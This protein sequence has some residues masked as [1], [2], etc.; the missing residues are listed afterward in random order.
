M[1]CACVEVDLVRRMV[2]EDGDVCTQVPQD[3]G[4]GTG[5]IQADSGDD[6]NMLARGGNA[7]HTTVDAVGEADVIMNNA[8]GDKNPVTDDESA[9]MIKN[10]TAN[11]GIRVQVDDEAELTK[12]IGTTVGL[13]TMEGFVMT[14]HDRVDHATI[15][16]EETVAEEEF[17]GVQVSVESKPEVEEDEEGGGDI[18]T[19]DN[20]EAGKFEILMSKQECFGHER[21]G[22]I[23]KSACGNCA[24]HAGTER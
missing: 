9:Y 17:E 10:N 13:H 3:E 11:D 24:F 2:A 19:P 20:K 4:G 18:P 21:G 5:S 12:K 6:L 23:A 8:S 7:I 1:R 14:K 16:E 22:G 15:D